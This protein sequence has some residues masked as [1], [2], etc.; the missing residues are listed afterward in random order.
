MSLEG[1]CID[2]SERNDTMV[3][4]QYLGLLLGGIAIFFL[5]LPIYLCIKLRQKEKESVKEIP[6]ELK[7]KGQ[8]PLSE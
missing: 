7:D 8:A 6:K 2:F 3:F 5:A 1:L 4:N